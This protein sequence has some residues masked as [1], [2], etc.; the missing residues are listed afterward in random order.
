MSA[1]IDTSTLLSGEQG[2]LSG[3]SLSLLQPDSILTTTSQ[4]S[5]K[6]PNYPRSYRWLLV[7]FQGL[8]IG[9]GWSRFRLALTSSLGIASILR[10]DLAS[11]LH[12]DV[13]RIRRKGSFRGSKDHR[14]RRFERQG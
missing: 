12:H 10:L 4:Q 5:Y 8:T 11:R 7:S 2:E 3:P 13:E 14:T 6:C 1:F 9:I